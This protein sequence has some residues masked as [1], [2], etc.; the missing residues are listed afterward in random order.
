MLLPCFFHLV[1]DFSILVRDLNSFLSFFDDAVM[2]FMRPPCRCEGSLDP[3]ARLPPSAG[4][5]MERLADVSLESP[6]SLG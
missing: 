3:R 6:P 4:L 1:L 5:A 2:L